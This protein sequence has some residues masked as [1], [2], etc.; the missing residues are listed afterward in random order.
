VTEELDTIDYSFN[1]GHPIREGVIMR[2]FHR[3]MLMMLSGF[4]LA[5]S[6][7]AQAQNAGSPDNAAMAALFKADQAVRA[8]IR[9]EQTVDRAFV[10]KMI[11]DDLQRRVAARKLLEA[12]AL[13]SAEDYYAAAYIFQHGST[14]DDYLLAH[15]L[16]L[17]AIARGKADATWIAAATLDRYLQKI[18][19]KQIYGTQ[20][21][22][23][24]AT[25]PTMEPYDP[26]IVPDSLRAAL[27]VPG[28]KEQEARLQKM[29]AMVP[30]PK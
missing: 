5:L 6:S 30:T 3:T 28:R 12:E 18:G 10:T 11:A 29:R 2:N 22:T 8:G 13:H 26:T 9:P 19:Q 7:A 4:S 16:A 17:A 20:Y 27:G 24:N 25:G 23:A 15:S 14:A 21:I 1:H